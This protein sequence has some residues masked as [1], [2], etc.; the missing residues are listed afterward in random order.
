MDILVHFRDI[1]I[2][3]LEVSSRF[4]IIGIDWKKWLLAEASLFSEAYSED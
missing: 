4:I 3:V 2:R 1:Y